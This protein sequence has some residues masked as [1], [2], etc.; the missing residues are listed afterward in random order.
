MA[1][2]VGSS[3]KQVIELMGKKHHL[4]LY[5]SDRI[6]NGALRSSDGFL[7]KDANGVYLTVKEENKNG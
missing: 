6:I 2:Y 5:F 3:K 1:L 4:S 7:L